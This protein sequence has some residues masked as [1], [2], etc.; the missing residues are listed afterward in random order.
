[1]HTASRPNMRYHLRVPAD[2]VAHITGK[3]GRLVE[4]PIINISRAG[5]MISCNQ[6][7]LDNL[8]PKGEAHAP[9]HSEGFRIDFSLPL[10][11]QGL[12]ILSELVKPA[13]TRRLSQNEFRIGLEFSELGAQQITLLEQ[14][15]A[16]NRYKLEHS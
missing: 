15:I 16:E 14:Y 10:Q 7:D 12:V 4:A 2:L 1:M 8:L 6:A 11:K 9:K 13:H 5:M 3:K